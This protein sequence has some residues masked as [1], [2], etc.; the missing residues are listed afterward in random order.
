[1]GNLS[2]AIE[3]VSTMDIVEHFGIPYQERRGRV[4]LLCPGHSD[5][6][7]GSCYIDKN[8][9]GYYC[10][11]CAEHVRK[12]DMLKKVSGYSN[13]DASEWFFRISGVTPSRQAN[14]LAPILQ[15]I[16]QLSRYVDNSTVYNDTHACE[17]KESPYGRMES[18][19]YLYSE[20]ACAKPLLELYKT[21]S[22]LFAQV[23]TA[24]LNNKKK[25]Y[26]SVSAFCTK[27]ASD[28]C[29][30]GGMFKQNPQYAQMKTAC[31]AAID[32]I[33]TLITQLQAL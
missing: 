15:L 28:K 13:A 27:H 19:E 16:K 31:E 30:V 10:Y 17:K 9:D 33:N 14:P 7:F 12:W 26:E 29:I 21:D 5:T 6:N 3:M 11:A 18:G 8:D 25:Q 32:D 1:M 20:P 22:V 2:E 24:A 4:L 23:M